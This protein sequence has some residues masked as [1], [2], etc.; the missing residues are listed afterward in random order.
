M[1]WAIA[2]ILPWN[3]RDHSNF[4]RLRFWL[5]GLLDFASLFARTSASYRKLNNLIFIKCL[6][7][8]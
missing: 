7:R 4:S 1:D 5:P 3:K 2:F 6:C 8:L